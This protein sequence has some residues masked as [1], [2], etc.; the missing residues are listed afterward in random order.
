MKG[1]LVLPAT[2]AEPDAARPWL[3][4][5]VAFGRSLPAKAKA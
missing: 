1:Y 4:R 2:L 3:E 5:A